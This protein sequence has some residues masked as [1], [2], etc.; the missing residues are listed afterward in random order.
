MSVTLHAVLIKGCDVGCQL[1]LLEQIPEISHHPPRPYASQA[2]RDAMTPVFKNTIP[3]VCVGS[4]ATVLHA[5]EPKL[6]CEMR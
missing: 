1:S 2:P 6:S 3:S 5:A 4:G